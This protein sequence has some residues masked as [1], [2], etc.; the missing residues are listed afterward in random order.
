[1]DSLTEPKV[2]S[3]LLLD[4]IKNI[5]LRYLSVHSESASDQAWITGWPESVA[6]RDQLPIAIEV[7]IDLEGLGE[8]IRLFALTD[9]ET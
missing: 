7:T 6:Q 2:K 5:Q 4:N 8:T 1:V 9:H 3:R